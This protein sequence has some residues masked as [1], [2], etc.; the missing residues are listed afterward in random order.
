MVL[1]GRQSGVP[2]IVLVNQVKEQFLKVGLLVPIAQFSQRAFRQNVS[3][4]HD[5][6]LVADLFNLAHDVR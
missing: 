6:N 4:V 2:A 5:R 3:P 1:A